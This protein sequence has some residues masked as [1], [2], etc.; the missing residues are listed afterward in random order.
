MGQDH[1]TGMTGRFPRL[2]T[3]RACPG[4]GQ[5]ARSRANVSD[6]EYAATNH[7]APLQARLYLCDMRIRKAAGR[8]VERWVAGVRG[9]IPTGQAGPKTCSSSVR[10]PATVLRRASQRRGAYGAKTFGRVFRETARRRQ[11]R[12]RRGTTNT[13]AFS[14]ACARTIACLPRASMADAFSDEVITQRR[15]RPS[16]SRW[17]RWIW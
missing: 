4:G 3:R 7:Q 15:G 6:S 11:D 9:N 17:L 8:N 12:I 14:L 13:V 10:P 2:V 1:H 16:A 5:G